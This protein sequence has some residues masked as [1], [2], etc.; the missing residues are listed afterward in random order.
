MVALII[1]DGE[2]LRILK[3]AVP[4]RS[5]RT[6]A[7]R[8]AQSQ[9][10]FLAT[11]PVPEGRKGWV[12]T[13]VAANW[14]QVSQ[15]GWTVVWCRP[16]QVPLGAMPMTDAALERSI[17][18]MGE[19]F[20]HVQIPDR[21]LVGD[22]LL[23]HMNDMAVCL[24]VTSVTGGVGK[25]TTAKRCAERAAEMG[26]PT[27]LID[28]NR[29]QS[30]VRSFFDPMRRMPVRTIADWNEGDRP[31]EGAN[32]GK[33]FGV[34]YDICF[35]PPTGVDV[36]WRHYHDYIQKARRLW[37]LV[38]V[39][40]DRVSPA[41]FDTGD[42][43]ASEIIT[44]LLRT[45]EPTL[46]IVKAGRQ[47]QGDALTMLRRM[48]ELGFPRECVGV[49]DTIPEGMESYH[50]IDYRRYATWL[51]AEHQTTQAGEL[52]AEGKSNWPDPELDTVRERVLD[53]A[54]PD[55]GFDPKAVAG[56]AGGGRRRPNL[57]RRLLH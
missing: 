39:D 3:E 49:K 10:A 14:T 41:D 6:P 34:R 52:L 22:I 1:G 4:E 53:W 44:P 30:S 46:F 54:M 51:G 31:Q 25:T 19:R 21:R 29:L 40:F 57:I 23:G 5:W 37:R 28:A 13:D 55:A 32:P 42:T 16:G 26:I 50:R 38:I 11:H 43:A 27:L 45:G 33:K 2:L 12:F 8:D 15:A 35:A 56:E 18:D 7:G 36:D 48:P 17:R 24:S 20:W 9:A 47:T